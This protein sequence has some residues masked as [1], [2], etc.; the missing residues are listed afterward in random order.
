M[1]GPSLLL[2]AVLAV[3]APLAAA[4]AERPFDPFAA[5]G[6]DQRPGAVLPRD[7]RFVDDDGRPVRLGDFLGA[8]PVLLAPVYYTCPNLC[9]VTLAGLF[10]GL[11]ELGWRPGDAFEVVA[12][13]IDPNETP[14]DAAK[15]KAEVL[16]RYGRNGEAAEVHFL[17]G[18]ADAIAK[19]TDTIGFNY[20]WDDRIQ[21]YAHVAAVS[22]VTPQGTLA[23]WLYGVQYRPTDLRLA[24][25][26]AGQGKIGSFA[27]QLLLL[28][29]HYDPVTGRY[30]SIIQGALRI[31]GLGTLA[32]LGTFIVLSLR[33]ER[34]QRADAGEGEQ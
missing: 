6:I 22:V 23:R 11:G 21:Q 3:V 33:R 2:A 27:D 34:R 5:A 17:T 24:L 10:T 15:V 26:D 32:G 30:G 12:V 19:V 16:K 4:G 1:T 18:N 14:A 28:C 29:Y 20:A 9:G 31:G 8:K 13:S 25:V 7:A